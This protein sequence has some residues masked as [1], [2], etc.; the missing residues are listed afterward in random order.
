MSKKNEVGLP[1]IDLRAEGLRHE[2]KE[3]MLTKEQVSAHVNRATHI[4]AGE[5][6]FSPGDFNELIQE[7]FDSAYNIGLKEGRSLADWERR[8]K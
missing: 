1:G 7:V 8:M 2:K 5:V 6:R 3:R 4:I